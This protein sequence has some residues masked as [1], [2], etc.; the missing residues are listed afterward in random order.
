[1]YWWELIPLFNSLLLARVTSDLLHIW[2]N[3][4]LTTKEFRQDA[5]E[6]VLGALCLVQSFQYW[7]KIFDQHQ[8]AANNTEQVR[9]IQN[10]CVFFVTGSV[11]IA[12][13]LIS[14]IQELYPNKTF[15]P[16][17]ATKNFLP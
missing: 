3:D 14:T 15:P 13:S 7:R 1:M 2:F 10:S 12:A 16:S 8:V 11:A 5:I 9:L 6:I 17:S 4:A